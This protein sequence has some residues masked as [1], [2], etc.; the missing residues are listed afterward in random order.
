MLVLQV[1]VQLRPGHGGLDPAQRHGGGPLVPR[2]HRHREQASIVQYSTV[3]CSTVQYRHEAMFD[4]AKTLDIRTQKM[5]LRLLL[6]AILWLLI[7]CYTLRKQID[8]L[9]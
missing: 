4:E 8:P 3:Q 5:L 2:G 9:S 7:I 1:G 6:D